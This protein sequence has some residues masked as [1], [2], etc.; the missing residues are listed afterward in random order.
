M[1][2]RRK[3]WKW[4]GN[5]VKDLCDCICFFRSGSIFFNIMIFENFWCSAYRTEASSSS[6]ISF[7]LIYLI[8]CCHTERQL[9]STFFLIWKTKLGSCSQFYIHC[10]N[11]ISVFTRFIKWISHWV[12]IRIV[13]QPQS[14]NLL[15]AICA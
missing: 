8:P 12:I 4:L 14:T 3:I 2:S 1:R 6:V 11:I 9:A 10:S 13:M 7:I 15:A 5:K